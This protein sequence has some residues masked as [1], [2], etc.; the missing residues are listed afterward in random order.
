MN[1]N[2]RNESQISAWNEIYKNNK[3]YGQNHVLFQWIFWHVEKKA[4][5]RFQA[6]LVWKCWQID[7]E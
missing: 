4:E 3:D 2:D 1:I 5:L 6:F 7:N